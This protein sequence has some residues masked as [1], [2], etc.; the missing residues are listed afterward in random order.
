MMD[1]WVAKADNGYAR[2]YDLVR[3]DDECKLELT[4]TV[5]PHTAE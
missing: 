2:K 4:L 5:T 1:Q 3:H